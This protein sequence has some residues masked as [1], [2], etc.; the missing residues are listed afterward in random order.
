MYYN[1]HST[2]ALK[3]R[4]II[5]KYNILKHI[6]PLSKIEF[7]CKYNIANKNSSLIALFD[8]MNG[9][10]ENNI[11]RIC[12]SIDIHE[13]EI[14]FD[15]FRCIMKISYTDI[16]CVDMMCFDKH[17]LPPSFESILH[18]YLYD[19]LFISQFR[20]VDDGIKTWSKKEI[21]DTLRLSYILDENKIGRI[22]IDK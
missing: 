17:K 2:Y 15:P 1:Y 9:I 11:N 8:I 4:N 22:N 5:Y 19:K 12:D 18:D 21:E 14:E 13:E 7:A 10:L 20:F 16:V 3:A 6:D